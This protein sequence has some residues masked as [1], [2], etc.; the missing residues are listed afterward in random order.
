MSSNKPENWQF[1][2]VYL[3]KCSQMTFLDHFKIFW[4]RKNILKILVVNFFCPCGSPNKPIVLGYKHLVTHKCRL[5]LSHVLYIMCIITISKYTRFKPVL[6][7][8]NVSLLVLLMVFLVFHFSRFSWILLKNITNTNK[9]KF[10][11]T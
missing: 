3:T 7:T 4:R 11:I 6:L 9:M 2:H 5:T 8:S 1:F 10:F